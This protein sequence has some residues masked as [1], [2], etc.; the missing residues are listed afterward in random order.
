MYFSDFLL[1]TACNLRSY[2]LVTAD[3]FN[4]YPSFS[5]LVFSYF[6]FN[7]FLPFHALL[8]SLR[9]FFEKKRSVAL[10]FFPEITSS[11]RQEKSREDSANIGV[12]SALWCFEGCCREG[13]C[14][15][16]KS[17]LRWNHPSFRFGC[18]ASELWWGSSAF[19]RPWCWSVCSL[20]NEGKAV[21]C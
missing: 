11:H 5:F 12:S 14:T 21:F 20:P 18:L 4:Y 9:R 1:F 7:N 8:T 17:Y 19:Q 13:S 15:A 6:L 2:C 16:G 3:S 10:N